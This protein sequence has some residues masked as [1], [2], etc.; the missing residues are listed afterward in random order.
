VLWSMLA[1]H[2]VEILPYGTPTVIRPVS[3]NWVT[4]FLV[5]LLVRN[6]VTQQGTTDV[7]RRETPS[8]TLLRSEVYG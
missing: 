4:L 8:D 3:G 2:P 1:T 7:I 5:P 6:K